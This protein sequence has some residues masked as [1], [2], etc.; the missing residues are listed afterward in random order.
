MRNKNCPFI[1]CL[2]FSATVFQQR[3]LAND[4]GN[5]SPRY[6]LKVQLFPA[7]R[8]MEAQGTISIP[9]SDGRRDSLILVLNDTMRDFRVD[10]VKPAE[11]AGEAKLEKKEGDRGQTRWTIRP[12]KSIPADEPVLLQFSYVGGEKTAF[13]F[14]LGPESS[15]ASGLNTAWYPQLEGVNDRGTGFLRLSTSPG[16]LAIS[17]GT[18]LHT[19]DNT[20]EGKFQF[21]LRRPAYFNF[22]VGKYSTLLGKSALP[23]EILYLQ[24]REGL[25]EYLSGCSK[26]LS[27]L[28]QQYGPYPP[29]RFSIV[30]VPSEQ[31]NA[32]DF[33]GVSLDGGII[34]A[35]SSF[36]DR[37]FDLAYF[38][39]EIGHQWWGNLVRHTGTRGGNIFDEAMVQYGALRT[40]EHFQGAY[41]AELFRRSGFGGGAYR[42]LTSFAASGHDHRIID[43]PP[44]ISQ[45]VAWTK[46]VLVLYMLSEQ[47]GEPRFREML[48][49]IVRQYADKPI[50]WDDFQQLVQQYSG[51]D[52]YW[53]F[54]QWFEREGA[55]RWQLKWTQE[56]GVLVATVTQPD[57]IYR[58]TLSVKVDGTN[59]QRSTFRITVREHET[60][61]SWPVSFQVREV[62]LDPSFEFL[63]WT[64]QWAAK[65]SIMKPYLTADAA[66]ERHAYEDAEREL[67]TALRNVPEPDTYGARF[68]YE[69]CLARVYFE[70]KRIGEAKMHLDT[71]L[72]SPS[73][74]R[75]TLPWA[76]YGLA[77]FA[78]GSQDD[79]LLRFAVDAATSADASA[80]GKTG[81]AQA[82]RALI[83][84]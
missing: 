25:Q 71:A 74:D 39:H 72:E 17:G 65:A 73:R 27:F 76:Y 36:L 35:S 66:R 67:K 42:Y 11:S 10:V 62:T 45:D 37:P 29:D 6:D 31:A 5:A 13:V 48:H 54:S 55:P 53:F 52:L 61:V 4:T 80:G 20:A 24:R 78:Q 14:S 9:K 7:D 19:L 16:Y 18:P 47:M 23:T 43:L 69:Y 12:T 77:L 64:D 51:Q 56:R 60:R 83:K 34:L 59:Y 15:F 70:Q 32:A 33:Q 63:H 57:P 30:E 22:A 79:S 81:A 68:L 2:A 3:A 58:A 38:A 49:Q 41:A 40:V 82:A 50:V 84:P 46:G 8:R 26:V 44:E 75:E 1:L 28:I 21:E